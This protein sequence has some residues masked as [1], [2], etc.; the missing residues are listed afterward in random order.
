MQQSA[1][2]SRSALGEISSA[3]YLWFSGGNICYSIWNRDP[4]SLVLLP[5]SGGLPMAGEPSVSRGRVTSKR[6]TALVESIIL[7]GS[8]VDSIG[9]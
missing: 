9:K 1:T 6:R 2:I 3:C 8:G 5:P 4:V 7:G